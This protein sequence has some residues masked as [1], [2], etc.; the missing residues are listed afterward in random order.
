MEIGLSFKLTDVN[1]FYKLAEA[2][3]TVGTLKDRVQKTQELEALET[4][5]KE[6]KKE[7]E[8]LNEHE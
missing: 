7:L 3:L 1:D 5:I 2:L 4:R 6:R 8:Q